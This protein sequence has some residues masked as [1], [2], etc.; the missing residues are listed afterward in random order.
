[1]VTAADDAGCVL[2]DGTGLLRVELR[3]F[4]RNA[5]PD[6]P[7]AR[8]AVGEALRLNGGAAPGTWLTVAVT[9]VSTGDYVMAIG[10]LHKGGEPRM[11]AHQVVQLSAKPQREAVWLLEVVEYWTAV[12]AR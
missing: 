4:L 8:P 2:D 12:V 3:A 10:P 11:V 6:A 9:A 7:G 5:P 1:M